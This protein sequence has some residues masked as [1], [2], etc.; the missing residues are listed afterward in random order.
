MRGYTQLEKSLDF[1]DV[2][3][4]IFPSN[5]SYKMLK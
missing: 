5:L 4:N 1:S 2:E 3:I